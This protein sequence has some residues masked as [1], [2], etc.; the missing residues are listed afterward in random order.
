MEVKEN[1]ILP[2]QEELFLEIGGRKIKYYLTRA[3]DKNKPILFILHGHGY[4]DKPAQFKSKNWNV[5]CP[6]DCFG[7]CGYG[8]WYLGEGGDFF[9]INAIKNIIHKVKEETGQGQLYFWGSSMGGYGAILHG[10]LNHAAAVYANI[11]QTV[12]LGSKY[13]DGGM[14]KYFEPIFSGGYSEYNDLKNV[15]KLRS[16]TKFYLCFNQLESGDYFSEQGLS[17]VSHI[18]GLRQKMY[19]EV[20]PISS[21]GKNHGISETIDLFKK[22]NI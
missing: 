19:L 11:P 3:V 10:Y 17:F 8:S 9:W 16:R 12:L 14:R 6:I 4:V 7:E 1:N 22:F 5:V 2:E 13:S 21:H 20:R 15:I 18:H